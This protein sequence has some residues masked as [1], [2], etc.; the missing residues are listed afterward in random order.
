MRTASR[1]RARRT[2]QR[3]GR[4]QGVA[5]VIVLWLVALLAIIAAGY[6]VSTRTETVLS[7][8]WIE[9]AQARASAEAGLRIALLELLRA[10]VADGSG[11]RTDGSVYETAFNGSRLRIAIIDEGGKIDLNTASGDL[12]D[13]L[14]ASVGVE[15]EERKRLL[16]AILDWRDVDQLR[17]VNGAED[18]DYAALGYPYGA[19]DRHFDSVEDLAL[20]L[21][22]APELYRRLE[23]ALTVYSG[24]AGINPAIAPRRVLLAAPGIDA[25]EVEHYIQRREQLGGSGLLPPSSLHRRFVSMRRT[26][27]IFIVYIEALTADGTTERLAAVVKPTRMAGQG[28]DHHFVLLARREAADLPFPVREWAR[29]PEGRAGR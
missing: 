8:H 14:L 5:L 11:L 18:E 24:E 12:I 23:G 4:H 26:S 27:G 2:A 3:P 15:D 6:T 29:R 25:A 21:G 7:R 20:V 22:M 9:S 16:D 10:G 19:G 28:D 17:R 13:G 1:V